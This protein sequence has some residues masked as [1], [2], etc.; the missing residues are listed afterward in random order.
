MR[1]RGKLSVRASGRDRE[2]RRRRVRLVPP[3][4]CQSKRDGAIGRRCVPSGTSRPE[5]LDESPRSNRVE[6]E[7]SGGGWRDRLSSSSWQPGPSQGGWAD[8]LL[9]RP[10]GSTVARRTEFRSEP[11][12]VRGR[13]RF[14]LE[15]QLRAGASGRPR[16]LSGCRIRGRGERAIAV[17]DRRGHAKDDGGRLQ[18]RRRRIVGSIARQRCRRDELPRRARSQVDPDVAQSNRHTG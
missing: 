1:R 14:L 15:L 13:D 5:C 12:N 16:L 4:R 3:D 11:R 10:I 17:G 8:D 7:S 6:M 18:P 2:E 9:R